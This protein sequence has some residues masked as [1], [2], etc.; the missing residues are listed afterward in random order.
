VFRAARRR[1]ERAEARALGRQRLGLAAAA[2]RK[3]RPE[4]AAGRARGAENVIR[5]ARGAEGLRAAARAQRCECVPPRRGQNA[6]C[7]EEPHEGQGGSSNHLRA[8]HGVQGL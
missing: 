7:N 2:H 1:E 5:H 4:R 6:R 8:D 3:R